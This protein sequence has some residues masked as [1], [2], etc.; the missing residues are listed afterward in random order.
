[1][2]LK[3]TERSGKATGDQLTPT[4][5]TAFTQLLKHPKRLA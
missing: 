1:L 3:T 2:F 4:R 5:V